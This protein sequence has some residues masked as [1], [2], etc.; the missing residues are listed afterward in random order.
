[1]ATTKSNP[2]YLVYCSCDKTTKVSFDAKLQ[3]YVPD[4]KRWIYTPQTNWFCGTRGHHKG[5]AVPLDPE[6]LKVMDNDNDDSGY[7]S[8]TVEEDDND[9][10]GD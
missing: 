6:T 8:T 7:Q 3:E 10:I 9:I 2:P 1:M 4:D 5:R